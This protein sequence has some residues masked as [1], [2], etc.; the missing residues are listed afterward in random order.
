MSG[1]EFWCICVFKVKVEFLTLCVFL[2][3]QFK[4]LSEAY[5]V[6]SDPEKKAQYDRFG[7]VRR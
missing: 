6:L 1:F 3:L 2:S 4:E 7:K 5:Q